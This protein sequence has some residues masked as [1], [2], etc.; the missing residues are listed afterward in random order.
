MH[1]LKD[2]VLKI[3]EIV[4]VLFKY[5]FKLHGPNG[6]R[7]L[8]KSSPADSHILHTFPELMLQCSIKVLDQILNAETRLMIHL[9]VLDFCE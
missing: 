9:W 3:L 2:E 8:L 1:S 5:V 6:Q 7:A 4:N